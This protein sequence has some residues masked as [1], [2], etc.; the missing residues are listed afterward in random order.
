MADRLAS[1]SRENI[2]SNPKQVGSK[3]SP[4]LVPLR[5]TQYCQK[6][7]LRQFLGP[8]GIVHTPPEK[9][10]NP[11]AVSQE[12]FGE[13]WLRTL[14]NKKL[15]PQVTLF[16]DLLGTVNDHAK[17]KTLFQDWL[18]KSENAEQKAFLAGLL[19]AE[20]QATKDLR[21]A[22][23]ATWTPKAVSR[24]KRRFRAYCG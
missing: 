16:Q 6:S 3:S 9:P 15:Y 17:A 5:A 4:R 12:K 21:A 7:L 1:V 2:E 19:L 14:L 22:F 10:P 20:E 24:L 23:L 8:R 18:S 13:S 11:L